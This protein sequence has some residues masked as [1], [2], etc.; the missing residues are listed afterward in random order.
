MDTSGYPKEEPYS[1]TISPI[2]ITKF[3]TNLKHNEILQLSIQQR[4][5]IYN[6][7]PNNSE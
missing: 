2:T 5:G 7:V 6:N 4:S 1:F 3:N